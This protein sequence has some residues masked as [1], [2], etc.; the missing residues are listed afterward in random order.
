VEEATK[1]AANGV[2]EIT[3]L[4]QNVAAYGLDGRLRAEE[5]ESPFADLLQMLSEIDTLERI[6]FI[7]PH[8]AFFNDKL[9]DAIATIPKVCDNVHLPMQSGADKILKA[10]NRRYTSADYLAIVTKLRKRL[11]DITFSTDVII[12]FPGETEEDFQ[13]TRNLFNTVEFD[14][15]YIFK[16]SP[17]EGTKAAKIADSVPT[18]V[19]EERNQILLEDLKRVTIK[20]N[21]RLVGTKVSVLVNGISKRNS[22]RWAGRTTSNKVV[23]FTPVSKTKRGDIVDLIVEKATSSTLFA[24]FAG[25]N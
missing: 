19:K 4:G 22:E 6:R 16:Y 17:R 7:S 9:I 24:R 20:R 8:P 2:K 5:N 14:N 15:A 11:P 21:E 12:G 25:H 23:V 1:L 13:A 18:N 3:L 10:M